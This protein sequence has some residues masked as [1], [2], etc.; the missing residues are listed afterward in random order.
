MI[1]KVVKFNNSKKKII[2]LLVIGIFIVNVVLISYTTQQR[3]L[4]D[5]GKTPMVS[6]TNSIEVE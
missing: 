4:R 6:I 5:L 1:S 2:I 3:E